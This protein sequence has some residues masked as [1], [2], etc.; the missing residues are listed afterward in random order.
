MWG[1]SITLTSNE[2]KL[3]TLF[4]K[5]IDV[6]IIE[7]ECNIFFIAT[8]QHH[9]FTSF[10][11]KGQGRKRPESK[12]ENI[13]DIDQMRKEKIRI[14]PKSYQRHVARTWHCSILRPLWVPGHRG[15]LCQP[16]GVEQARPC[17]YFTWETCKLLS[18]LMI[19]TRKISKW[20][21][22]HMMARQAQ[23]NHQEGCLSTML[24]N[25]P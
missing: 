18:T 17:I 6:F 4:R 22:D 13:C 16:G 24:A 21:R 2:S 19:S 8:L 3:H 12:N 9:S 5:Y 7:K 20:E 15:V 1:S 25:D 23:G 11:P 14:V 10:D